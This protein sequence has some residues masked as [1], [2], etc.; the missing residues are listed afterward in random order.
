MNRL[1]FT[2]GCIFMAATVNA[3]PINLIEHYPLSIPQVMSTL[4]KQGYQDF[5]KIKIEQ[6]ENELEVIA[7][8][9]DGDRVEITLDLTS[10][11]IIEVE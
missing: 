5:R 1:L 11:K 3:D 2:A 8:E 6:D 10:G 4:H 9:P 7:H